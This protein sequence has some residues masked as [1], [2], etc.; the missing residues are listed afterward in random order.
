MGNE[1]IKTLNELSQTIKELKNQNKKIVHCHGCFDLVHYGHISHFTKAKEQGDVLI[2]TVTPDR[3]IQKGPGRPIFKEEVRMRYLASMECIDYVALNDWETAVETIKLLKPDIYSKG[4]EVLEN[5]E[6]DEIKTISGNKSN[7][8][9]EIEAIE[10]IGGTF[11]LTDEITFSSSKMINESMSLISEESKKFLNDFKQNFK[12]EDLIKILESLKDLRVLV[13]GET[14]LDEYVY[15]KSLDK[16]GKEPMVAYKFLNSETYLGGSLA[17]VEN[18]INYTKNVSLITCI[19]NNSYEFIETN[20]N[21]N[22]ERNIFIQDDIKTM[23]KKRYIDYYKNLKIYEIYNTEELN[24]NEETEDKIIKYLD[25]NLS[26]FDLIIVSDFGHGMISPRLLHYLC[27]CDK[28]LAVNCQLNAGNF[29]YNFITKYERADFISLNEKELRLPIQEKTGDIKIPLIK[30]SEKLKT[31]KITITTG[32]YGS[33]Y[34]SNGEYFSAPAFVEDAID[35]VGAGDAILSLSSL[36]AYKNCPTQAVPFLN[37][38]LGA[39]SV[40]IISNKRQVSLTELKRFISYVM[41]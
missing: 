9:L 21:K 33:V 3:F 1:K 23:I 4:K 31:N 8:S 38:C 19:G 40:R 17:V 14:I 29:G 37:N 2:I 28:F 34:Y 26:R 12:T 35:I 13:I 18:L 22:I 41:K 20:L 10:S 39:L 32:R 24:I 36:L 11:H 25:E 6:I 15:C 30:L 5:A 7:L 16:V 27:H